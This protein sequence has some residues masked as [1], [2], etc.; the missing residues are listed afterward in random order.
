MS[1]KKRGIA[2]DS[3]ATLSTLN[4]TEKYVPLVPRRSTEM[5]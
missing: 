5:S 2:W 4:D 1:K 3:I